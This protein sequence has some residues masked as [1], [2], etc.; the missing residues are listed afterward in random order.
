[1]TGL[2]VKI[3]CSRKS[4]HRPMTVIPVHSPI[5]GS[6]PSVIWRCLIEF[7][8]YMKLRSTLNSID[9]LMCCQFAGSLAGLGLY[10]FGT[11]DDCRHTFNPE[12]L[13]HPILTGPVNTCLFLQA[14]W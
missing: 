7:M 10:I 11:R 6:L 3:L 9:D 2:G 14:F 4:V 12:A 13:Q 5:P 1:M 8:L